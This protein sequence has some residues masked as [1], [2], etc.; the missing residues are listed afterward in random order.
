MRKI[1]FILRKAISFSRFLVCLICFLIILALELILTTF[2]IEWVYCFLVALGVVAIPFTIT[3]IDFCFF[4]PYFL[5][6]GNRMYK[7]V[8]NKLVLTVNIDEIQ[9]IYCIKTRA[10]SKFLTPFW[11]L[12][13]YFTCDRVCVKF[14]NDNEEC[15]YSFYSSYGL[16]TRNLNDTSNDKINTDLLSNKEAVKLAKVLGKELRYI[17]SIS[18]I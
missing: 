4:K 11:L 5:I 15:D 8:K 2:G 7:F 14:N 16:G 10:G 13:G 6:D 12:L 18:E 9:D 3:L 17:N 1:K